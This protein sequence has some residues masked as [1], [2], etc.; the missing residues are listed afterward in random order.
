MFD[1]INDVP[2]PIQKFYKEEERSEQRFDNDGNPVLVDEEYQYIDENDV[3]Q[4]GT[5]K[6]PVFDLVTYVVLISRGECKSEDDVMR[7]AKGR[8]PIAVLDKFIE[9]FFCG[10]RWAF[11]DKYIS[12]M[13]ECAAIDLKAG[14]VE[15]AKNEFGH[16]VPDDP[17]T[18]DVDEAWEGGKS[19]DDIRATKKPAPIEAVLP[20][21]EQYKRTN[22]RVLRRAYYQDWHHQMDMQF[23]DESLWRDHVQNVKDMFPK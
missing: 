23:N 18:H 6:V 8:K 1:S 15:R 14:E 20:T 3:E 4:M 5:K 12:W 10:E 16:F 19:P 2:W 9:M 22:Y 7:V 17:S 11:H 13:D 21:L